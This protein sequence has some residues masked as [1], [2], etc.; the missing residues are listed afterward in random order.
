MQS[1]NRLLITFL[2][3][4]ASG[5]IAYKAI[6]IAPNENGDSSS[7]KVTSAPVF[8]ANYYDLSGH[9][10]AIKQWQGKVILVNFWATWCP[11][12]REEMPELS[13]IQDKFK[14]KGVIVLGIS[15]DDLEK[16]KRFIDDSP[17]TYPILAGDMD[18]MDLSQLVGNS[19]GILPYS[20]LIDQ[21]ANIVKVFQ[22]RIELESVERAI[23]AALKP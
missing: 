13:K 12:C 14:D 18:G 23:E 17:V 9:K 20:V 7:L 5:F 22:G 15:T 2:L 21:N 4:L 1:I 3:V 10:Q 11:P 8:A 16:T 19:R 6:N